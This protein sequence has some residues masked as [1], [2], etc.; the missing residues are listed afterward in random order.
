MFYTN[1][2]IAISDKF[3]LRYKFLGFT[4]A[5]LKTGQII[6]FRE[7]EDWDCQRLLRAFGDLEE[8]YLQYG[9]GTYAAR[10]SLSF[11]ATVDTVAVCNLNCLYLRLF[12]MLSEQGPSG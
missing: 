5:N 10:L 2:F 11:S 12:I 3:Y 4:E 1:L 6:F 9:A 8:V 7:G